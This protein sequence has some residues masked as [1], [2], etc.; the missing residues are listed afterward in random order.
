MVAICRI[1]KAVARCFAEH[2]SERL[3]YFLQSTS[4]RENSLDR[5]VRSRAQQAWS[6]LILKCRKVSKRRRQILQTK[7]YS[8]RM[9]GHLCNLLLRM[10]Q[11]LLSVTQG[12]MLTPTMKRYRLAK[13]IL[14]LPPHLQAL[15]MIRRWSLLLLWTQRQRVLTSLG[16]RLRMRLR[17]LQRARQRRVLHRQRSARQRPRA[18]VRQH[19]RAATPRR[20][21]LVAKRG[22]RTLLQSLRLQPQRRPGLM[23]RRDPASTT[24]KPRTCPGVAPGPTTRTYPRARAHS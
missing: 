24:C 22:A 2:Q 11:P 8:Y 21:T 1:P 16:R 4:A 20:A 5:W 15:S 19:Q 17:A 7:T 3:D 18:V 13:R 6:P 14:Q 12:S 10:M 9:R 23:T